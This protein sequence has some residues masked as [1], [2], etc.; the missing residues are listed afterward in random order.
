MLKDHPELD[1]IDLSKDSQSEDLAEA[2]P[3]Y[4]ETNAK[5]LKENSIENVSSITEKNNNLGTKIESSKDS[6]SRNPF[7][8]QS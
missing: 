5:I 6:N 1:D 8:Q 2:Q 7:K 4:D 3:S